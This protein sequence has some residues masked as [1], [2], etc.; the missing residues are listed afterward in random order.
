MHHF[1]LCFLLLFL[2]A[3]AFGE[4]EQPAHNSNDLI[5]KHTGY[6]L[7]YNSTNRQAL[8]VAYELTKEELSQKLKR[9]NN[10]RKDPA[11]GKVGITKND[12]RGSGYD[13]GHLC[14][15]GDQNWS[16]DAMSDSFFMTNMSPQVAGFN[17][18]IWLHLEKRV[19][20]W[21]TKFD[22]IYIATGPLFLKTSSKKVGKKEIPVPDHFFKV[23][24][25]MSG[26]DPEAIAFILPNKGGYYNLKDYAVTIDEAEEITGLDFFPELP[27]EIETST[28]AKLN[29]DHWFFPTFKVI[30][31]ALLL[32]LL[33]GY[34]LLRI[35]HRH[36]H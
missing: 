23:I 32:L 11:A 6:S 30:I 33:I 27:D 29:I 3:L 24:L 28:E 36:K 13:R 17:R 14:P 2:P 35:N 12:F 34:T 8:W 21:A 4:L 22:K 1:T 15:A 20:Y 16:N 7:Q 18:G 10:Y 26:G 19:R 9:T 31:G 5:I 25:D